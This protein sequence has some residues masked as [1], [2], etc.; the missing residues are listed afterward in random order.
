MNSTAVPTIKGKSGI[1]YFG[2]VY[3]MNMIDPDNVEPVRN[4]TEVTLTKIE[5]LGKEVQIAEVDLEEEF[6]EHPGRIVEFE[7][8]YYSSENVTYLEEIVLDYKHRFF[9]IE[10]SALNN[11]Q[12][13]SLQYSYIMENLETDWNHAGSRNYVSYA[14]MKAGSYL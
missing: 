11:L 1:F 14:N 10:F 12:S 6:E 2:G 9:S 8:E 4:V 5:V 13:G 3:G 7:G